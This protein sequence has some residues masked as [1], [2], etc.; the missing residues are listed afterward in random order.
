MNL[1]PAAVPVEELD[2][3]REALLLEI[4]DE[5]IYNHYNELNRFA[6][7]IESIDEES[8]DRRRKERN[9][10]EAAAYHERALKDPV[11]HA[12]FLKRKK[13]QS[14]NFRDVTK[15]KLKIFSVVE[16]YFAH[17]GKNVDDVREEELKD[18]DDVRGEERKLEDEDNGID[19]ERK[20]ED[21][22]DETKEDELDAKTLPVVIRKSYIFRPNTG[23]FLL[24]PYDARIKSRSSRE[25]KM[26]LLAED[27]HDDLLDYA[28]IIK[29]KKMSV[30][31]ILRDYNYVARSFNIPPH[32]PMLY[33]GLLSGFDAEKGLFHVDFSDGDWMY[34]TIDDL[35][36]SLVKVD[37]VPQN[38]QRMCIESSTIDRD[39]RNF[40]PS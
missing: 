16:N 10:R 34:N 33:Y 20:L 32:P 27:I 2:Y 14:Q 31:E 22:D 7:A 4:Y 15:E 12:K 30:A 19:E 26:N 35:I 21:D 18:K 11:A 9:A 25:M 40:L 23:S 38:V 39:R 3:V 5:L 6:I 13:E 17:D 36:C 37:R 24:N 28:T 29:I 1:R 8:L